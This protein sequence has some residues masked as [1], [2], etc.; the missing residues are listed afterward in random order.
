[1]GKIDLKINNVG[2]KKS[3]LKLLKETINQQNVKI[4]IR[5]KCFIIDDLVFHCEIVTSI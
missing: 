4:N 1:M 3:S 5:E 2:D